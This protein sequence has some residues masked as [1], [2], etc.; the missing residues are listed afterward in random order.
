M[1]CRRGECKTANAK[2]SAGAK[3]R[4]PPAHGYPSTIKRLQ[5]KGRNQKDGFMPAR[6][7]QTDNSAARARQREAH[8]RTLAD[9]LLFRVEKAA[10]G[11]RCREPP[12]YLVPF[13]IPG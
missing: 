13:A 3:E 12:T 4:A 2:S 9:K 10:T 1:T 6:P 11:L 7:Q 5:S 8:L